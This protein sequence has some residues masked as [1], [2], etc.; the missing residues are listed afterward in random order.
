V[1]V[2]LLTTLPI[3][4][5]GLGIADAGIIFLLGTVSIASGPAAAI[6]ILAR[7]ITFGSVVVIGG[8]WSLLGSVREHPG[9]PA[10]LRPVTAQPDTSVLEM[11]D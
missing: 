4:P 7:V 8:L 9:A 1:T 3:T 2:A 11:T 10:F 5:G 6:A